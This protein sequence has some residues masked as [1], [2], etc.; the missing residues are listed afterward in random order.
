MLAYREVRRPGAR[1]RRLSPLALRRGVGAATLADF[2]ANINAFPDFKAHWDSIESQ[3][4]AE[5][6]P[7]EA[8]NFA[9]LQMA[10]AFNG[11]A[12]QF[13]MDGPT[14]A[15]NAGQ[16]V[17]LGETAAGALAQVQALVA[18]G[19][20]TAAVQVGQ[21]ITGLII[22]GLTASGVVTAGVGA[23]VIAG[24]A[25][26]ASVLLD[27]F[28]GPPKPSETVCGLTVSGS[29]LPDF[30]VGCMTCREN[31]CHDP[32]PKNCAISPGSPLWRSFPDP[33]QDPDWYR[34][35]MANPTTN[36]K[37]AQ[38]SA[39]TV[40]GGGRL[41]DYAFYE[42]RHL[43]CRGAFPFIPAG[44]PSL[45]TVNQFLDA[46]FAAWKANRSYALN[47]LTPQ[48]DWRVLVQVLKTWNRVHGGDSYWYFGQDGGGVWPGGITVTGGAS[49]GLGPVEATLNPC[50]GDLH[51]YVMQLVT[52]ALRN[53]ST[54]DPSQAAII[55]PDNRSLRIN[56]GPQIKPPM[57]I[58][59][60]RTAAVA[61]PSPAAV[62]AWMNSI[63]ASFAKA[64]NKPVPPPYR[65][66]ASLPSGVS[67]PAMAPGFPF[68]DGRQT[69]MASSADASYVAVS[70]GGASVMY[71]TNVPAM[72][73][74][75]K[76]ATGAAVVV[77][78][79]AIAAA[80]FGWAKG[81]GVSYVFDTAWDKVKGVFR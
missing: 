4:G 58:V 36:W 53:L 43:E 66:I 61:P 52:Q 33:G 65:P 13:G 77:G 3:L 48:P 25:A 19:G 80:F 23:A 29:S 30:V 38:W 76:V 74:G 46:F 73:T 18:S 34:L 47:R 40:G 62:A 63:A 44:D 22:G 45:P 70:V 16:F 64:L 41:I 28:G 69:T 49:F 17:S 72:S 10:N 32:D 2:D 35:D 5:G 55:G 50:P 59:R 21:Q 27:L 75:A 39:V 71:F 51:P 12:S 26:V 15:A 11:L 9:K 14:A 78:G 56:V 54:N 79:S 1:V 6:A 20:P 24:V 81:K 37:D 7:Q 8:V 57:K 42:Y 60:L 67:L 68:T 31:T